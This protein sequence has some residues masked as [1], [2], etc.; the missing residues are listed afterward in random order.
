MGSFS[1]PTSQGRFAGKETVTLAPAVIIAQHLLFLTMLLS[2]PVKK[3]EEL[4]NLPRS[5]KKLVTL[6]H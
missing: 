5:S 2:S 3:R 1:V 4:R 6:T